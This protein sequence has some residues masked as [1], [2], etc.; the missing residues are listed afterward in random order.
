MVTVRESS[1]SIC[2][3]KDFFSFLIDWLPWRRN[4]WYEGWRRSWS[5]GH[6]AMNSWSPQKPKDFN[7]ARNATALCSNADPIVC[8]RP[9]TLNVT[10]VAWTEISQSLK[11][12]RRELDVAKCV[13]HDLT[14]RAIAAELGISSHT[15]HVHFNRLFKKLGVATRAQL[16]LH[17]VQRYLVLTASD[18][19]HLP[20][21]CRNHAHGRCPFSRAPVRPVPGAGAAV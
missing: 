1:W 16:V 7:E 5:K 9:G 17:I 14:D 18:S 12:S 10:R 11:L 21:I 8:V 3:L 15:V 20:P 6:G 19:C 4:D 13:F 2:P